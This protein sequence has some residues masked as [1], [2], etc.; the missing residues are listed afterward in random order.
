MEEMACSFCDFIAT[1][2]RNVVKHIASE[3]RDVF[4]KANPSA[5]PDL[6]RLPPAEEMYAPVKGSPDDA[7][8]NLIQCLRCNQI[9]QV[10]RRYDHT[11]HCWRNMAGFRCA[12]CPLRINKNEKDIRTHYRKVHGIT[13]HG[14]ID[15]LLINQDQFDKIKEMKVLTKEESQA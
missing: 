14:K 1:N 13:L 5:G 11:C 6:T 9:I 12:F 8:P 4:E 2:R 15:H 7:K 3:H 10:Q